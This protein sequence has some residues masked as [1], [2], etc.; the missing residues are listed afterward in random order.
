MKIFVHRKLVKDNENN[1]I[2]NEFKVLKTQVD[3][4]KQHIEHN[5]NGFEYTRVEELFEMCSRNT[6][7]EIRSAQEFI[8]R[9]VEDN[10]CI[11]GREK[12]L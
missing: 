11:L 2:G 10:G 12:V 4:P 9:Y 1:V 6:P 7:H 5:G 3:G 8:D